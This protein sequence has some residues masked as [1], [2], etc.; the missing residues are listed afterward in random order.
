MGFIFISSIHFITTVPS[1]S[2]IKIT[3]QLRPHSA[4]K[5][6][7]VLFSAETALPC[8]NIDNA[9]APPKPL[10]NHFRAHSGSSILV[11]TTLSLS[12]FFRKK[13]DIPPPRTFYHH[14][15]LLSTFVHPDFKA[16]RSP[17][18]FLFLFY[19]PCTLTTPGHAAT[20]T[21]FPSHF[22]PLL[23]IPVNIFAPSDYTT[24]HDK[25]T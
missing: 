3:R 24:T 21:T 23:F 18:P 25:T 5:N 22:I 15:T 7:H 10:H 17:Q 6:L 2:R 9:H 12:P 11:L 4:S 14:L 20:P 8:V 13:C 1:S 19:K 16:S